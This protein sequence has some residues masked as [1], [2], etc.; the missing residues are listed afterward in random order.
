[1]A[2]P[3][4]GIL[5]NFNRADEGPPP[6]GWRSEGLVGASSG[7]IVQSNTCKDS[8]ADGGVYATSYGPDSE[9]FYT[10]STLPANGQSC[11]LGVRISTPG[12]STSGYELRVNRVDANPGADILYLRLDSGAATQ[13][14]ATINDTDGAL[15]SGVKFGMDVSGN[16]IT[17]YVNRSGSWSSYSSQ[18]DSTYTA[19]GYIGM[20]CSDTSAL[21]DDFGGGTVSSG[22]PSNYTVIN[23]TLSQLAN[24]NAGGTDIDALTYK[25]TVSL[26]PTE[27]AVLAST[28]GVAVTADSP[29]TQMKLIIKRIIRFVS[30]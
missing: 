13:L 1:M 18:S 25:N 21:F 29:S 23:G 3:T 27:L 9:C 2:F 14:G 4:T 30:T 19:A 24:V 22:T 11:R 12:G 6:T 5:D 15:S 8:T 7:L 16:T 28:A 26:T 17:G 20:R 10:W